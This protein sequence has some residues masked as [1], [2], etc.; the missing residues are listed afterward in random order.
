M[1]RLAKLAEALHAVAL[2][3]WA[4]AVGGS[5]L[6]AAVVFPQMKSLTPSLPAYA[7]YTGDHWMIAAGHVARSVFEIADRVEL[8]AS[9]VVVVALAYLTRTGSVRGL[10]ASLRWLCVGLAAGIA[11]Y[12]GLFLTPRM[13][14]ALVA[15]W[16]AAREGRNDDAA[17]YREA[18][19]SQHPL[20]SRLKGTT[21]VAL[22]V[23]T[24]IAAASRKNSTPPPLSPKEQPRPG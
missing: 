7:A 20:A 10:A 2:T 5:A 22:L 6:A 8:V 13:D 15:Y 14:T 16:D 19:S 24:G 23:A 1:N 4:I 17:T 21:L 11:I 3:V 12:S 9:A 18:F